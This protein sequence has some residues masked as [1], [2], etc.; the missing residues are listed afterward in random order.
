MD[1]D[2]DLQSNKLTRNAEGGGL[3]IQTLNYSE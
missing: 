2:K 1:S 3:V